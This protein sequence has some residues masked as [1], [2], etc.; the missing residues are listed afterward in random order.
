MNVHNMYVIEKM[1]TDGQVTVPVKLHPGV[2]IVL[3]QVQGCDVCDVCVLLDLTI[4]WT[5]YNI[6]SVSHFKEH[7]F[8]SLT[9]TKILIPHLFSECA[10]FKEQISSFH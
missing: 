7:T 8:L 4:D 3:V 10:H 2:T 5:L 1:T 6:I 9:T